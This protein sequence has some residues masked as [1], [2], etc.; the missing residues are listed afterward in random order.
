[1]TGQTYDVVVAFRCRSHLNRDHLRD[2][3]AVVV[4]SQYDDVVGLDVAVREVTP[5]RKGKI[6]SGQWGDHGI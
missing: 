3:L 6:T 5:P 1:M 4:E 2:E